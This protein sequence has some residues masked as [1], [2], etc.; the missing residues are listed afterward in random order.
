MTDEFGIPIQHKKFS[1]DTVF[2]HAGDVAYAP[3]RP[4]TS[5]TAEEMD[6]A[7]AEGFAEGERSAVARAEAEAARAL[8]GIRDAA[9]D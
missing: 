3:P 1:F 7:R 9:R 5:F 6:T 4:K 8:V 2:D